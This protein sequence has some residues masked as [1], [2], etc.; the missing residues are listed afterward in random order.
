M[1]DFLSG[2]RRVPRGF[3][4]GGVL[5][6]VIVLM[7]II[8]PAVSPYEY[9]QMHI[10]D[11]LKPPSARYWLGTDEFGRDVLT[12]AL[13]GT[14]T[15]L[16]TGVMATAVSLV[17]G[18][19]LGLLAGYRRGIIDEVIMRFL[20]LVMAFPPLMLVLLVA[21]VTDPS[22]WKT[23]FVVGLLFVPSVTRVARSITLD[24]SSKE[25]VEA[26]E[27]RGERTSYILFAELLPNALPPIIVEGSLRV[28]FAILV[29]AVLSFLG[30]GIQPPASDWGLMISQARRFLAQAP[31]IAIVP[32]LFMCLTVVSIS[33][34]GDGLREYLDPRM[35]RAGR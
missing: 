6:F 21:A 18:V 24:V 13:Y 23:A 8:G 34:I 9:D 19:P 16:I 31:W 33:I 1:M 15:S 28:T 22:V 29:A 11:R 35:R 10:M 20:D 14:Q 7:A 27:A 32:G 4:V 3:I 25:F 17:I 12:R 2:G 30:F 5:L 26:A